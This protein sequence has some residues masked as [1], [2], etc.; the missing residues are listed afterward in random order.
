MTKSAEGIIQQ[1]VRGERPWTDLVSLGM[2]AQPRE[3]QCRFPAT[4][5]SDTPVSVYDLAKGLLTYLL[6]TPRLREW[7][8]IIEAMPADIEVANHPA[9]EL[10]LDALWRA[11]FG[12]SISEDQIAVLKALGEEELRQP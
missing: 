9:C 5:P 11:S 8:F 2:E 4:F 7:A 1:V 6:D 10:V 12:E 3:S